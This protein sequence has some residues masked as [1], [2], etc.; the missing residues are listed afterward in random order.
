MRFSS[1]AADSISSAQIVSLALKINFVALLLARHIRVE[2]SEVESIS[3]KPFGKNQ[4]DS[5]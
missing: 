2:Q 3:W 1:S 5:G 4:E